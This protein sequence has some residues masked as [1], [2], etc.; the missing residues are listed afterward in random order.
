MAL[1][2]EVYTAPAQAE[3]FMKE[4]LDAI[5]AMETMIG[6]RD[7]IKNIVNHIISKNDAFF[8]GRGLD[9]AFL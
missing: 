2:N 3:N 1:C 6:R 7:E 9:Y 5:P 8:I 4:L